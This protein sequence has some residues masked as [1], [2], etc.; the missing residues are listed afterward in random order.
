MLLLK[1]Q[2]L[3]DMAA[4]AT[5][6]GPNAS[7]NGDIM[8][9]GGH[10]SGMGGVMENSIHKNGIVSGGAEASKQLLAQLDNMRVEQRR[11]QDQHAEE[12]RVLQVTIVFFILCLVTFTD[13]RVLCCD[14]MTD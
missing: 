1:E 13:K 2:H 6:V 5:A 11:M 8:G 10:S 3:K 9:L 14:V 4:M 12:R 7:I